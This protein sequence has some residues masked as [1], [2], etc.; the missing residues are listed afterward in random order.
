MVDFFGGSI[1]KAIIGKGLSSAFGSG[2]GGT[3]LG[4]S[5][6]GTGSYS[7]FR[8]TGLDMPINYKSPH[9]PGIKPPEATNYELTLAIWNKRLFGEN[10]YTNIKIPRLNV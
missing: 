10:S 1:T 7:P 6:H 3:S 4:S 2:S 9:S 5:V 8:V